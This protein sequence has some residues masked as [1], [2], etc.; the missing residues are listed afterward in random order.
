MQSVK[1]DLVG[2]F[3]YALF[4]MEKS[5]QSFLN[6]SFCELISGSFEDKP[7]YII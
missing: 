1:S 4:F 2:R 7:D 5:I 6:T 3:F